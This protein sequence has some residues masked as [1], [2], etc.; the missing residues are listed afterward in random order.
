MNQPLYIA[1]DEEIISVIAR[2]RSSKDPEVTL[3]FPKH[4]VVTQSIINLK[5]LAREGEK[6]QKNLTLVSQNENARVL[7]EKIGFA[8]LPYTQEMEKESFSLSQGEDPAPRYVASEPKESTV[9][10]AKPQGTPLP[11]SAEIGS[12]TF[13]ASPVTVKTPVDAK[14]MD[15]IN[16]VPL[17]GARG[18]MDSTILP[19][20]NEVNA[21]TTLRVRNASPE[22][23]P[24]LNSLRNN[25]PAEAPDLSLQSTVTPAIFPDGR[26]SVAEKTMVPP[27]PREPENAIK[28]FF[29]RGESGSN[30]NIPRDPIAY[31]P[32]EAPRAFIQKKDIPKTKSAP[33]KVSSGLH[34]KLTWAFFV[35]IFLFILALGGLIFFLVFPRATVT[36]TPQT[37][38]EGTDQT[39]TVDTNN[40]GGEVPL[41]RVTQEVTAKIAGIASGASSASASSSGRAKGRIKIN[42]NFSGEDQTLVAST[43]FESSTGKIYRIGET[44]TVPGNGSVEANVTADGTGE[45]YNLSEGNFTIPGFKG[46][47]KFEK[48]SA[49]V[50]TPITGGEGTESASGGTFIRADE[51][52][53]RSRAADEA[54]RIFSEETNN[55]E[56][57][58]YT[59]TDELIIERVTETNLPRVGTTPG[60]YEY[61]GVFKI[62]AFSA[63]KKA[64]TEAMAKNIRSEYDGITFTSKAQ[65]LS[66]TDFTLEENGNRAVIKAHMDTVLAAKLD[67]NRIKSDLAGKSAADLENFT[68]AHPE[69]KALSIS[70]RPSWALKKVPSNTGRINLVIE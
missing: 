20:Q 56:N 8:T 22:R 58:N 55:S 16:Q 26:S 24:G 23:P 30:A 2:L 45:S 43:R 66:F 29:Q 37:L 65:E 69:V 60:E 27:A 6:L 46:T 44:I 52:T 9:V 35:A 70:F 14:K 54:R 67:E 32:Q 42:N 59:F 21:P 61:T 40:P 47:D 63:S 1:P 3:V 33:V 31:W 68:K 19:S 12:N 28:D 49:N 64:I 15:A 48:F 11:K 53:L 36:I 57:E 50:A 25:A 17:E 41:T 38:E 4:S 5:L 62:T 7:A 13:F 39:F 10:P 34:K 51:E 18:A